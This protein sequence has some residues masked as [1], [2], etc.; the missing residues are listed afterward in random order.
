[1]REHW[2]P[3][4]AHHTDVAKN[5]ALDLVDIAGEIAS[6]Q[7]EANSWLRPNEGREFAPVRAA[8]CKTLD[9]DFPEPTFYAVQ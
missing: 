1:M 6:L 2:E 4:P 3:G 7:G 8:L 9:A 5:P